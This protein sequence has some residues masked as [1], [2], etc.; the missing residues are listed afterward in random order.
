VTQLAE[1]TCEA[2]RADAPKVTDAEAA[3]LH[4]SVP[5]WQLVADTEP[6][7]LEREFSFKDFKQALEFANRVGEM[8]EEQQHHP[9]LLVD[10]GKTNVTWFTHKING[11]HRNDFVMA[12][13]TD[14]LYEK[15]KSP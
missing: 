2:C 1:Q 5:Q 12:A 4:A 11:L 3:E 13:K 15:A 14:E 6:R 10:Y 9:S 7:R 8:A